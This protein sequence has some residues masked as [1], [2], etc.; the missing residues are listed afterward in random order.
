M[1]A[2]DLLI[3]D[4]SLMS[5]RRSAAHR[6]TGLEITLDAFAKRIKRAAFGLTNWTHSRV[7]V[8]LYAGRL[9]WT[10]SPPSSRPPHELPKPHKSRQPLTRGSDHRATGRTMISFVLGVG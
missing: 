7:R 1:P 3:S 5:T 2:L 6:Q 4:M 9:D 10:N 8:L